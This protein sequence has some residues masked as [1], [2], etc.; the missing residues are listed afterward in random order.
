[1]RFAVSW[2]AVPCCCSVDGG[3]GDDTGDADDGDEVISL[4]HQLEGS[5]SAG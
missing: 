1:M 3:L 4:E 5:C 2:L